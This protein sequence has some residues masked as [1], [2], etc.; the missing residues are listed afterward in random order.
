VSNVLPLTKE[1]LYQDYVIDKIPA[2]KIAEK[3]GVNRSFIRR[4]FKKYNIP[5]RDRKEASLERHKSISEKLTY[6]T[7]YQMY[8]IE[9]KSINQIAKL[10]NV[11]NNTIKRYLKQYNID[12]IR[13]PLKRKINQ[14]KLY[15]LYVV[16]KKSIYEI[17]KM[18]NVDR[19]T[20]EDRLKKMNI[21]K[22]TII[23]AAKLRRKDS[24]VELRK[25]RKLTIY[26]EWRKKCLKRDNFTCQICGKHGGKLQVHHVN[27]FAEFKELR[28]KTNNGITL[29]EDCHQ[30]FHRI[31]GQR[32]N[33]KE[34]LED[35]K[36][37]K[38]TIQGG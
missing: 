20:I 22:R 6:K 36:K 24:A 38:N 21:N 32:N 26:K 34:Q 12:I 13:Y 9:E 33:T 37:V 4:R 2:E 14:D 7:L 15:E 25:A 8:I 19:S 30:E 29:C 28:Y 11:G 1:Q 18:F 27:N 31:F 5:T 23:E 10:L 16:E 17:A 3:Y 35:F